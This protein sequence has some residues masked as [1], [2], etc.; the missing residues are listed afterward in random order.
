[1]FL[2]VYGWLDIV[3]KGRNETHNGNLPD[4]VKRHDRYETDGRAPQDCCASV[5]PE[6]AR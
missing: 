4:W 1:M 5:R 3:P 2:G 6:P